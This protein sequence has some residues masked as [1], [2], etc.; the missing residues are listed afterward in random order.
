MTGTTRQIVS[1]PA[2]GMEDPLALWRNYLSDAPAP[3]FPIA[4]S[5]DHPSP[6]ALLRRKIALPRHKSVNCNTTTL[7]QAAWSLINVFYADCDDAIF[8][9]ALPAA[10]DDG[11]DGQTTAVPA[12]IRLDPDQSVHA[13]LDRI[14]SETMPALALSTIEALGSDARSACAFNN[15]LIIYPDAMGSTT[16]ELDRAINLECTITRQGA[17]VQALFDSNVVDKSQMQRILGSFEFLVVQLCNAP[18]TAILNDL[19]IIGEADLQEQSQWNKEMP[20]LVSECMHNLVQR[21]ARQKPEAP[22]VCSFDGNFTYA[23][24]DDMTDRLAHLLVSKGVGP[25]KLV[26]FMFEKSPW[27]IVAMLATLKAGGAFA[28]LDPAHVWEDTATV[29]QACQ[30]E[31]ILCSAT[32]AS[33]FRERQI[34]IVVVEPSL[35]NTLPSTPFRS[36]SVRPEDPGYII[37]TS[38]STGKPK[39]IVCSHQAWCTNAL[40]HGA[41][42]YLD[43]ESR[44]YQF[45]AYTFDVSISDIFTTLAF[46]GCICVPSDEERMND[47]A[48]SMTRMAANHVVITPTVAQFLHPDKVPHLR[49]LTVGGECMT[50]EIVATWANRVKLVNSYGPA[51]CTSR[52]NYA[53][54]SEGDDPAVIG[55]SLGCALWVTQSNNPHR[56]VPIGA[57]GELLIEGP[58][59]A[60]GYL[61]DEQKTQAAFIDSP[62]WLK[63]AF[64]NRAAR[65]YRTGDLVQ[66]TT[67]GQVRFLGR[68]D[69]QVKFH[70]VRLECGHVETKIKSLLP[71]G[72]QVVVDKVTVGMQTQKHMLA[73]FVYLTDRAEAGPARPVPA[74]SD[75]EDFIL[76]LQQRIA[77]TIPSHMRPNLILPVTMI[78]QGGTGKTNRK[79]LQALA[80]DLSEPHLNQRD[81]VASNTPLS[82]MEAFLRGLWA[83]VLS[84]NAE[85]ITADDTFFRL[86]GDSVS[87]M[88]LVA[89]ARELSTTITVA[90]IFQHPK[91]ADLALHLESQTDTD[92][93]TTVVEPFALIGGLSEYRNLRDRISA[94]YK[95]AGHRVEDIY[96]CTPVQEAFMAETMVMPES[97]ILQEVIKLPTHLDLDQLKWTWEEV[98]AAYPIMRTRLVLLGKLGTCQVLLDE[99]EPMVW[100]SADNL[101]TYLRSDRKSPMSYGDA[102]SRLAIV[103]QPDG[104]R[105]LVW[106]AHHAI[107]DGWMHR[108]VLDQVERAYHNKPIST[109]TPFNTF[110]KYLSE[111][112]KESAQ[113]YW[114]AQFE[115][116]DAVKFPDWA[117][118]FR[119][120]VSHHL[121]RLVS[122]PKNNSDFTTSI[123]LRASW[124]LLL[125]QFSNSTD[126]VLGV[127]QS[128]RDVPVTGI[129]QCAGPTLTTVPV[130]VA[131]NYA[132][133]CGRYLRR[134]QEQQ[135]NMI[136]FQHTGLQHI[137][138]INA[139]CAS[140]CDLRNLLVVQPLQVT[141]AL[142]PTAEESRTGSEQLSF[143]L[144]MECYLS[145]DDVALHCGFDAAVIEPAQVARMLAQFESIFHQ[146]CRSDS[147]DLPL[148]RVE[149]ASEDDLRD[150]E[151]WNPEVE[152]MDQCIHWMVEQQ[153]LARPDAMAVD[154]WDG[155]FTYREVNSHAERLA[156][157]LVQLGVGP[158]TFVPFIFEKSAWTVVALLAI[159][160][161]GG[162]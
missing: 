15:Q 21:K 146:L 113:S 74:S 47:L 112:R 14:Q 108:L 3:S 90:D 75:L 52:T 7:L 28:P 50:K 91:L 99:S 16:I 86:G 124:A 105:Y 19:E 84:S 48:G 72:A 51:E 107:T 5:T 69:T 9:I 93:Q 101:A 22:A 122:L 61:A 137:Q 30:A 36:E 138:K 29:M 32:H 151:A 18:S 134:L 58:I 139:E 26:P 118:T 125:A 65:V 102:L 111:P 80:G 133:T 54:V 104:S 130:R 43:A 159:L 71:G 34:E 129:E 128:G 67:D 57:V 23:A 100:Q 127:T 149:V 12:R 126:I 147:E 64:P 116:L 141:S 39:G 70:G 135:A 95:I 145:A 79:A 142:L 160:K 59:L 161:A 4:G 27:T 87:A 109:L 89:A 154:A 6:G 83:T 78:P 94:D 66:Y 56:L 98:A 123:L 144:V 35:I 1:Q 63:A 158:E 68:R 97:Y 136:P 49:V 2:V 110:V 20:A 31:L 60:D 85:T 33:R 81:D 24:L 153:V 46:G 76:S 106:T 38:G 73:A 11:V 120:A 114:Q 41:T 44:C 62:A 157:H 121:D 37:F 140:A 155:Q 77:A 25:G 10:S 53:W 103:K 119:P 40:A 88:K 143:G 92:A 42:E 115:G 148:G 96:P 82:N 45:A 156:D 131:V 55:R 150:L 17:I 162:K 152:P 13:L 117:P 132:E 8:G